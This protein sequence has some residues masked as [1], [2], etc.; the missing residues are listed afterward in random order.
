MIDLH[1]SPFNLTDEDI[2]WV[3]TVK[4]NMSLDEKIGQLFVPIGHMTSP[5]YLENSLLKYHIGGVM[6]RLGE[7]K[8]LQKTFRY[9]QTHSKIPL[10]VGA[11][12]ECGGSGIAQGGTFFATQMTVA[13]TGDFEQA[14]RL[15][16]IACSEAKAVGCNW[17]FAPVVDID[18]NYHNPITNVRTY[19]S[20]AEYVG[21]YAA[22]YKRGADE[23]GIAVAIKHFPGDGCDEVDQHILCSVN[24]MSCRQWDKTYGRVYK[25]LIDGGAMSV[26]VGHIAQ[27]KYEKKLSGENKDQ[28]IPATHS[29]ALLNGLLRKKLGFNGVIVTDST[30]M[31]GFNVYKPRRESVPHSIEA[32]CDLFLFNK[33]LGEDFDFMKEGYLNGILSEKR[34]DEALTRILGMKAA[35]GLHKTAKDEIVPSEDALKILRNKTHLD[36]TKECADK[37]I[38]LVKDTQNALLLRPEKTKKILLE[39][40]GEYASTNRVTDKYKQLLEEKG[41]EVTVYEKESLQTADF[42]VKTFLEK[43]DAVLYVNNMENASNQVT[44]RYQWYTFFGNGNNCPW[45]TAEVPVI[46]I[47]HANPYALLDTPQIKTYINAYTNNDEAIAAVITK[48]TEGGFKGR[49]PI[50]PFC[51]KEYLKY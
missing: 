35:L 33:D 19:G 4:K 21:K 51:G 14:Y 34:L 46:Y 47:S 28:L 32:G 31:V 16:K 2:R 29:S 36:W 13:A 25:S 42:R 27:P 7:A 45:F 48:L 1:R 38:T 30:C 43:F 40:L 44:N 39:V 24:T 8:E 41:F 22:A 18:L 49:S 12:L 26:M 11:N 50:D 5:E 9:L 3:E 23:E 10:L 20:N 15:G 6:Y 37:A 17:S